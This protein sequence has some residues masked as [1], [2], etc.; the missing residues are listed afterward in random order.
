MKIKFQTEEAD[1]IDNKGKSHQPPKQ[2]NS[3]K[4]N[5]VFLKVI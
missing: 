5:S 4:E 1:D 3:G 2:T